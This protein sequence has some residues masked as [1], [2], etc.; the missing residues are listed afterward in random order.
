MAPDFERLARM[1]CPLAS[2]AS[3]GIRPF[4]SVLAFSCWRNAPRVCR[5][6]PANSPQEFDELMST[7]RIASIRGRGGSAPSTGEGG[8][9]VS[10]RRQ[11]FFRP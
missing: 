6:T 4:S 5:K 7:T 1:P 10:T 9:P 11:N 8:S 3:S 2:L